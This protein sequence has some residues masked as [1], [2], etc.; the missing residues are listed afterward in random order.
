MQIDHDT[1]AHRSDNDHVRADH[2]LPVQQ[3][4]D[5]I[6][7]A[8]EADGG[9]V[10]LAFVSH[11]EIGVRLKGTCLCCPSAELTLTQGIERTLRQRLPWVKSVVRVP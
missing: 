2:V 11:G 7:P 9:G 8:M 1:H 3:A 6:R 4:L 10:E 5:C